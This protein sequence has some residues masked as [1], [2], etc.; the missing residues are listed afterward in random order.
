MK[1]VK[2]KIR[3]ALKKINQSTTRC[4]FID[5]KLDDSIWY[6]SSSITTDEIENIWEQTKFNL[7]RNMST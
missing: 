3:E 6:D 5:Q 4:P 7:M 2:S 1:P